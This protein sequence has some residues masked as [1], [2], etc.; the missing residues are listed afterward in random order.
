MAAKRPASPSGKRPD[1]AEGLHDLFDYPP[2]PTDYVLPG[3]G[4]R[5]VRPY[6]FDFVMHVKKR[7]EGLD[8]VTIFAKEFPARDRA[9]YEKAHAA[10]YLRVDNPTGGKQGKSKRAKTR[11]GGDDDDG[12]GA[13]SLKSLKSFLEPAKVEALRPLKAGERVRHFLHRHEP[14]VLSHT[15][16]IV[17]V[18][19]DLVAVH[20]PAT[21]PVHP[22]GQYRKNTVLG[23]LASN[24]PRLGW[25]APAHRL[26]RNVSG[27]LLLARNGWTASALRE[28]MMGRRIS[29]TY[30]ALVNTKP[31]VGVGVGASSSYLFD[32]DRIEGRG[33]TTPL[34]DMYVS[35][36]CD[37]NGVMRITVSAPMAYDQATGVARCSTRAAPVPGAKDATTVFTVAE[38]SESSESS[39][40]ESSES[41]ESSGCVAVYCE[42]RTGR[43]HQIRA[44]L[45]HVGHPIANDVKYGGAATP[46]SA[47]SREEVMM[48]DPRVSDS[49]GPV[50]DNV[51]H[52]HVDPR[53][54]LCAHCPAVA[55]RGGGL[56][57]RVLDAELDAIWLHCH[58][59]R[60]I[61]TDD[62]GD[63]NFDF[64]CPHPPWLAG[65]T[66][67]PLD[68]D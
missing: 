22:T 25:L 59:Y 1:D 7:H 45:A 21:V 24:F 18:T 55:H 47:T 67:R 4:T 46:I 3:D 57:G 26:D 39:G 10:G 51:R 36:S 41:S 60:T 28:A 42:P 43:T 68:N 5:L 53:W 17:E 8:V 37:E 30:V 16:D 40:G 33:S 2:S 50:S 9:Y 23:I 56:E 64:T 32:R 65:R 35:R 31:G 34:D 14:P 58:R 52:D 48:D 66:L 29:K 54:P 11:G 15:V 63:L 61:G 20:K 38:A 12:D 19:N 6:P 44:H 49:L 13:K 27:L 62:A